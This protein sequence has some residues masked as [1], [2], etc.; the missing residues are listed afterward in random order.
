VGESPPA[1][2]VGHVKAFVTF[3]KIGAAVL[4]IALIVGAQIG[5]RVKVPPGATVY[6]DDGAR[7][8]VAPQCRDIWQRFSARPSAKLRKTD[9]AEVHARGYVPDKNCEQLGAFEQQGPTWTGILL[10]KIGL[11]EERRYW[12]DAREQGK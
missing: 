10:G 9:Y 5:T 11:V 7:T 2:K 3:L 12:W 4:A 6:A 8:I 1:V